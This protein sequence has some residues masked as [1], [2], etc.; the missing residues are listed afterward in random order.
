MQDLDAPGGILTHW[1]AYNLPANLGELPEEQPKVTQL[2]NGGMQ[3]INGLR[4]VGYQGPCP[5]SGPAHTYRIVIYAVD[6]SL[7]LAPGASE[8][9]VLSAL[10]GHILEESAITGTYQSADGDD[11]GGGGDY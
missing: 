8:K 2:P 7:P 11:G 10:E 4:Q 6:Q 9:D 1:V 5:P 3:G